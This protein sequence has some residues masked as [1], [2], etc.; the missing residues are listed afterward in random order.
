MG[1]SYNP[2]I[3]TDGLVLCLDAANVK[4]YPGSGTTW[5]DISTTK[6]TGTLTSGATYSSN[7]KGIIVL[8]GVDDHVVVSNPQLFNAGSGN[9]S[10]DCWLKQKTINR[11]NGIVE[12]RATGL[13]GFLWILNYPS[14]GNACFFLNTTLESGQNIYN[15]TTTNFATTNW[16]H[17]AVTIDR[18]SEKITFYKNGMQ[19]GSQ[20]SITS[21]GTIDPGSG[22]SY[23]IGGD[24]GG[25]E[26]HIDVSC[27]KHYNRLLTPIEVLQ[28]FNAVR[29]RFG[30]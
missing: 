16:M 2:K 24:Y 17:T 18:S 20:V 28:N 8:D 3:V 15:S 9:F 6:T 14:Q 1:I 26:A 13:H 30:I 7:D 29:G 5:N 12:G 27:I 11:Y 21:S 4:S 22:Y 25:A 10:I 19:E 23:L